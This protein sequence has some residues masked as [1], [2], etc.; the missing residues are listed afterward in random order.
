MSVASTDSAATAPAAVP[1]WL[2]AVAVPAALW[3]AGRLGA[4]NEAFARLARREAAALAGCR[5]DGL[6][7]AE[8]LA[9][10]DRALGDAAT[11]AGLPPVVSARLLTPDGGERPVEIHA[12]PLARDGRPAAVPGDAPPPVLLTCLDQ[13]DIQHVQTSLFALSGLLG[14]I[15]D[16]APLATLVIDAAHRVT[17]WN[18]ACE[19]LTG[20]ARREVVGRREA[21]RAMFTAPRPML[22]DLIVDGIDAA[23][24]AARRGG[25]GEG[26]AVVASRAV[27]GGLALEA[28]FPQFGPEGAWLYAT[29]APLR[30]AEGRV[31]GAIE[32]LQDVSRRRRTEQELQRHRDELEDLVRRRSAELAATADELAQ[33][34]EE[35]PIGV[36]WSC[37]GVLQRANPALVAMLGERPGG[38]VGAPL[39][40]LGLPPDLVARARALDPAAAA[41]HAEAWLRRA[42]GGEIWVQVDARAAAGPQAAGLW[43][44]MQDRSEIRA[45]HEVLHSRVDELR[46]TNHRLEEAQNQLLQQDK[47][48][49]IGQLAAGVAHEINNPIA[50]VGA[51]LNTL[52]HYADEL[53]RRIAGDDA[54]GPQALAELREDLPVLLDECA[55][56]LGRV[57]KIVQDLKDFSR[58]DQADWQEADLNAGLESTLN[59]LRHELKYKARVERRLGV[60]PP[61][62]CLP[63]QLNQVFMNLVV[64]ASQ[65]LGE[66]GTVTL[67]SGTEGP[68]AWVQVDDDGC[69]M[70]EAVRRRI[71]EPFFTTKDVGK[72]TGLGLSLS[73]SIVKKHGG[74]IQVRSAPGAGSSFRV[75]VPVG[76]PGA[77]A[78]QAVPA[79]WQDAPGPGPGPGLAVCAAAPGPSA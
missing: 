37:E 65:A 42:D 8:D 71:F 79:A 18:A 2:E 78:G 31:V 13:S 66:A 58:V 14:Q 59:V 25:E 51:N 35:A 41:L 15:V 32:T 74:A 48:A 61:V 29:A 40:E 43:W 63:G 19:R 46:E 70:P 4:A 75:W 23:A 60:L 9:A 68:W 73:F 7:A 24:A 36:A 28:W 38:W 30:D 1:A 12:R 53:L 10:L 67:S 55:D 57:R 44:M 76:G 5:L 22:A 16:G 47:M 45:A 77:V 17:H 62:R 69:G 3:Q 6:V 54:G 49:M 72:G 26:E 27:P 20:L 52:R 21:W 34:I 50:F 33:F 64:N 39:A 56:G 11:G